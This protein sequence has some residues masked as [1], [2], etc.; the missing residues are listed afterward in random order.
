M[1]MEQV[2]DQINNINYLFKKIIKR[3]NKSL[4]SENSK[5][6]FLWIFSRGEMNKDKFSRAEG[7]VR[8]Y[9]GIINKNFK[10]CFSSIKI[11]YSNLKQKKLYKDE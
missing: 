6:Q 9:Y 8:G 4:I 3:K 7:N 1:I 2:T 11:R 5:E 10:F